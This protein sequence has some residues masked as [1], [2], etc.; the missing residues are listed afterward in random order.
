MTGDS[1][2]TVFY[3]LSNRH[4]V[5][6]SNFNACKGKLI[7][8]DGRLFD[9]AVTPGL[10]SANHGDIFYPGVVVVDQT[11]SDD[12]AGTPTSPKPYLCEFVC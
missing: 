6:C 5:S 9:N 4:R 2:T 11:K 7:W 8:E 1:G 3:G 10:S 12:A